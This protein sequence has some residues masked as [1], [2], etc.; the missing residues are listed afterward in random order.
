MRTSYRLCKFCDELHDI[1]NWPDNH[2][3]WVMDNRSE[4]AAPMIITDSMKPIQGMHDGRI[5]DSKRALRAS[6]RDHGVVEV[7]DDSSVTAPKPR[8]KKRPDRKSIRES[9]NRAVSLTN[10]TRTRR[11]E[12]PTR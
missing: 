4:L 9:V 10:L 12:L 5:Y 8:Q 1:H 6:Y 7:G 3:E 2:R 11:D